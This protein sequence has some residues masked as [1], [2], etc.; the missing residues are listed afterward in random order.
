MINQPL[1]A[2]I[3]LTPIIYGRGVSRY[4]SNLVRALTQ[5]S[6]IEVFGLGYS[7]RQ[8][9]QLQEFVDQHQL[10]NSTL[11]NLPPSLMR[12]CWQ[13][14][15]KPVASLLPNIDLFHSWDWL[16]PPD[17]KLPLVST[18]HDLA[19]L[20]FPETA[21]PKLL[22][23]HRRSWHILK[24]RK[25][26]IIA[27]S[28]TTKKDIVNLLG[29]PKYQVTVVHE[30]L[31]VEFQHTSNSLREDDVALIKKKL[32]LNQPFLLFVGT[33]EPR[34]NLR[35]L[36]QAWEPLA[37][38]YQLIVVGEKGWDDSQNIKHPQLRFLGQV[39]D[40]D[41]AVLYGEADLFCYPSLYEG[42][43]L[44]ILESFFHGT[45]V[46]TSNTSAM[47]EVAGNAAQLVDPENVAS[48]RQGIETILNED[49]KAQ[50]QRLQRM[51][52]R[53]QMFSWDRVAAETTR[54]YQQALDLS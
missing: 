30:A 35:R 29:I 27:V 52:I 21:H 44:P 46:V 45:P 42:F 9:N 24:Q 31:P 26:Q 13:F 20:K 36:I 49:L 1:K 7:W 32:E 2:G 14:K 28:R 22:R 41:L 10:V 17:V 39:D 54:V 4:T 40:K 47:P 19:M 3:D 51:I 43:G 38:D 37:D 8:K 34:K 6:G 25:A 33:R 50:R 18:I 15:H 5:K 48:I 16:Q 53:L 12:W 23:A 11:L